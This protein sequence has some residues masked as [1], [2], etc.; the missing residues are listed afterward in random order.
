MIYITAAI[1]ES[2]L[3]DFRDSLNVDI[4]QKS[5]CIDQIR[6]SGG[7]LYR[8]LDRWCDFLDQ[9]RALVTSDNLGA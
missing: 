5:I 4:S 8:T 6:S 7:L 2:S 1:F 9:I 3:R